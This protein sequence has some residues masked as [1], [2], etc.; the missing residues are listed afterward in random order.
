MRLIDSSKVVLDFLVQRRSELA[1]A[2]GEGS[3]AV[4]ALSRLIEVNRAQLDAIL[5]DLHPTLATVQSNLPDL[6]RA[7]AYAGPAFYGQALAGTHGPWQDIYIAAL[8]P[9]IIGIIEDAQDGL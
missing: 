4:K 6:N 8:G 3:A 5:D 9:D 7:L 1:T 2:L